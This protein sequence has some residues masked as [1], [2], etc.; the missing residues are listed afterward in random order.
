MQIFYR[1]MVLPLTFMQQ[2]VIIIRNIIDTFCSIDIVIAAICVELIKITKTIKGETMRVLLLDKDTDYSQRLKYFFSKKYAHVQVIICDN[3]EAAERM[4]KEEPFDVVFFDASF[5][6]V[7][8]EELEEQ[9]SR[10]AFAYVSDTYEIVNDRET[11]MKFCKVSDMYS[12]IC[13]LY[14]KKKKRVIR[15]VDVEDTADKKTEIITFLPVHGG[16]GSST[17]AAACAASLASEYKVLYINLE[18]RP[19][20]SVYFKGEGKRGL[21]DIIFTL[22]TKYTESGLTQIINESIQQDH[23]RFVS[24]IR[25]Y[26]TILDCQ[27]MTPQILDTLLRALREK[28]D[29]RFIIIDADFIVDNVLSKLIGSSDKLVFV[30]SGADVSNTKLSKIQRYLDILKRNDDFEMPVCYLLLNQYYGMNDELSVARDMEIIARIARYRT[31][32]NTRVS[33]QNVIEEI[34]SKKDVFAMLN[35]AAVA[36]TE[37]QA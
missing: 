21:S 23:K 9:L 17:M 10:S 1:I 37:Q 16:A 11:I 13:S 27:Y 7:N 19:S 20:D 8:L 24:F 30:S 29:Y 5:D 22:K 26:G 6:E 2:Y 36:Q 14:E 33:S 18:Q 12:K 34:L 28:L 3:P 15:Q 32:D 25:G 4:M 31:D 35:P